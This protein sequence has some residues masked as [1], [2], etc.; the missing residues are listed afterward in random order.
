MTMISRVIEILIG[1]HKLY[2]PD[3]F[4]PV[5]LT[6]SLGIDSSFFRKIREHFSPLF[7]LQ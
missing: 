2:V 1:V 6:N 3:G 7:S 4:M 5:Y